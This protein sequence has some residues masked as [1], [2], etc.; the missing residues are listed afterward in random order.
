MRVILNY[1]LV[2]ILLIPLGLEV[3]FSHQEVAPK[4]LTE[5]SISFQEEN[6]PLKTAR[7]ERKISIR[8]C[9]DTKYVYLPSISIFP[10]VTEVFIC[11]KP[12]YLL[13]QS[14]LI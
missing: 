2:T 8:E 7:E 13:H 9:I 14:L 10:K 3:S 5:E 4:Q 1:I 12:R 11:A 6:I